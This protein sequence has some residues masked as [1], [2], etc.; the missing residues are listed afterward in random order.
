MFWLLAVEE[1]QRKSSWVSGAILLVAF[2]G[3]LLVVGL[4][5]WKHYRQQ[6]EDRTYTRQNIERHRLHAERS[7]EHMKQVESLLERIASALEKGRPR[8]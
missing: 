8:D 1:A 5:S 3:M 6:Q 7:E 4:M 2:G